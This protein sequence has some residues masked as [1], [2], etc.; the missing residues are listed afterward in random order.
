M[1]IVNTTGDTAWKRS[2]NIAFQATPRGH[3]NAKRGRKISI[4]NME[5]HAKP[6]EKMLS[7]N[8]QKEVVTRHR[9]RAYDT[10]LRDVAAWFR[11]VEE[12]RTQCGNI[13][14]YTFMAPEHTDMELLS[15]YVKNYMRGEGV[16]V[17]LI[18]NVFLCGIL[19]KS[20][21]R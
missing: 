1:T 15:D 11:D 10:L 14:M 18:N 8:Q 16:N 19:V 9:Y 2:M 3:K 6:K 5:I 4:K 7:I 12:Y 17:M 21:Y 20:I 13:T